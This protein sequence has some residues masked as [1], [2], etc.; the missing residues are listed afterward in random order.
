M[1]VCAHYSADSKGTKSHS[2]AGY[3]L[4]VW[5]QRSSSWHPW[6][7]ALTD[8]G[9]KRLRRK[10][11]IFDHAIWQRFWASRAVFNAQQSEV[12]SFSKCDGGILEIISFVK[13]LRR[14]RSHK[15]IKDFFVPETEI[16]WCF[17][18]TRRMLC[19]IC[20][21]LYPIQ[22]GEAPWQRK[23]HQHV[24]PR[25]GQPPVLFLSKSEEKKCWKNCW[26]SQF[27]SFLC[28]FTSV[29]WARLRVLCNKIACLSKHFSAS[30]A[31]LID[32]EN[33]WV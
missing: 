31:G 5:G 9:L 12:I 23:E 30:N 13:Q 2:A 25:P 8:A 11:H 16:F 10:G 26:R 20:S 6:P 33:E 22:L 19:G 14:T 32:T 1:Q 24:H 15:N 27:S 29:H 21:P 28:T 18:F 17:L 3:K 7:F 4:K